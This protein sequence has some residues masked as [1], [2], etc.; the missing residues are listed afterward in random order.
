MH[1]TVTSGSPSDRI[2]MENVVRDVILSV[3]VACVVEK[4]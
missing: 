4:K 1:S 3:F 2:D